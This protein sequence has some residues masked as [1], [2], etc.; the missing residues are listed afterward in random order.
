M[1]GAVVGRIGSGGGQDRHVLT[2]SAQ[3][4]IKLIAD[5]QPLLRQS[6][7]DGMVPDPVYH[8]EW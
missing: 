8:F 5:V 4:G 2:G 7:R 1:A 3:V 6:T